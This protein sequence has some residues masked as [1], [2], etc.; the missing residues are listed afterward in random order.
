M[1]RNDAFKIHISFDT[2]IEDYFFKQR[3]YNYIQNHNFFF[4]WNGSNT[5]QLLIVNFQNNIR[6]YKNLIKVH[7]L[8]FF[9]FT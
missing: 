6:D 7:S 3:L 4:Y 5:L 8:E 2:F 1:H 9:N